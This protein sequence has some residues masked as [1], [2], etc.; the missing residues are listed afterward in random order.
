MLTCERV[1][2]A[3]CHSISLLEVYCSGDVAESF[4]HG[5]AV[6]GSVFLPRHLP[7]TPLISAASKESI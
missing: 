4:V 2:A 6:K 1:N 7:L 3:E 5:W